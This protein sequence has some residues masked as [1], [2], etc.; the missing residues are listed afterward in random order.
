VTYQTALE[1]TKMFSE[2][3]SV[4]GGT[5]ATRPPLRPTVL[6]LAYLVKF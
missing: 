1:V 3:V 5:L 6:N 2:A 4:E